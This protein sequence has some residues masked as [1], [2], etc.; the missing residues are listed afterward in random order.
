M[1]LLQSTQEVPTELENRN[2]LLKLNCKTK[3]ELNLQ[4]K[5]DVAASSFL[6]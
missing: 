6:S 1:E 5:K 4:Q 3:H 2:L